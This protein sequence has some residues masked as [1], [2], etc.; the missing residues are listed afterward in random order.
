MQLKGSTAFIGSI[1]II[2]FATILIVDS[3][4]SFGFI[5]WVVFIPKARLFKGFRAFSLRSNRL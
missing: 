2:N 1:I 4:D 5:D 3:M